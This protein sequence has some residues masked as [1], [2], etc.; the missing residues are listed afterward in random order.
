MIERKLIFVISI[1]GILLAF[2]ALVHSYYMAREFSSPIAIAL[3]PN[4]ETGYSG[5]ATLE[6]GAKY[7][8]VIGAVMHRSR[9]KEF[10]TLLRVFINNNQ[11]NMLRADQIVGNNTLFKSE[12]V[13]QANQ[14]LYKKVYLSDIISPE[15]CTKC[16]IEIRGHT[17]SYLTGYTAELHKNINHSYYI[18]GYALALCVAVFVLSLFVALPYMIFKYVQKLY[19]S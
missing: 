10:N 9:E 18:L 17:Q 4:G 8:V 13:S 6:R 14:I 3:L 1:S 16:K 5:S 19:A 2:F 7:G 11:V 12:W 15:S